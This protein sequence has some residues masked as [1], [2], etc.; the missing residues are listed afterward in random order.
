MPCTM[1]SIEC[2]EPDMAVHVDL[3]I[4]AACM[5][6]IEVQSLMTEQLGVL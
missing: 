4:E 5:S 3:C 1:L 6:R 2:Q